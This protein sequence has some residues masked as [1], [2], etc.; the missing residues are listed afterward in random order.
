MVLHHTTDRSYLKII[1]RQIKLAQ[2]ALYGIIALRIVDEYP[3][4]ITR[5]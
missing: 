2:G 5:E 4:I 1:N 3:V